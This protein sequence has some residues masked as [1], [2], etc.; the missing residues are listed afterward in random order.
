MSAQDN[1]NSRQFFRASPAYRNEAQNG[2]SYGEGESGPGVYLTD[3]EERAQ[4]YMP[5]HAPGHLLSVTAN[6]SNPLVRRPDEAGDPGEREY[7]ELRREV[8]YGKPDAWHAAL[9]SRGYDA[10]EKHEPGT[11]RPYEI[12]VHPSK[13]LAVKV[14]S[15]SD[16]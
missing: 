15:A 10:V 16:G 14:R 6:V 3:T 2:L 1:L 4:V 11:K 7:M 5:V 8:G 9:A 12:A 13:I